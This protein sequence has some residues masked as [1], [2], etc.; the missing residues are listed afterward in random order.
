M[1]GDRSHS[2]NGSNHPR[3][4]ERSGGRR[5]GAAGDGDDAGLRDWRSRRGQAS[6]TLYVSGLPPDASEAAVA[7]ALAAFPP[8]RAVRLPRDRASGLCKGYAFVEYGSQGDAGLVV[9]H[10]LRMGLTYH[11]EAAATAGAAAGAGAGAVVY[12]NVEY[13]A[14]GSGPSVQSGVG[15]T[16]AGQGASA[17]VDARGPGSGVVGGLKALFSAGADAGGGGGGGGQS[18]DWICPRCR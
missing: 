13:S 15:S 7:A 10:A 6:N 18:H 16:A 17:G 1:A 4:R 8:P 3:E 9:D 11:A 14:P 2:H 5:G 12:L